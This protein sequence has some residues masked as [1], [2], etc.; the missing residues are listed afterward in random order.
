MESGLQ[1]VDSLIL[2]LKV[3]LKYLP[4]NVLSIADQFILV[5]EHTPEGFGIKRGKGGNGVA[6]GRHLFS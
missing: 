4:F 6:E 1:G 5:H 3:L 2:V